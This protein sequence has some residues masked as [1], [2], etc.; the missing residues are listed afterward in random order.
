MGKYFT[1]TVKPTIA[2]S[3]QAEAAF[4]DGDALFDWTAFDLPYAAELVSVSIV[5]RGTE[6]ADQGQPHIN[7]YFAKSIGGVAPST[8]GSL[9]NAVD[10]PTVAGGEGWFNHVIG[11]YEFDEGVLGGTL[12]T[13]LTYLTALSSSIS[14]LQRQQDQA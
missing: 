10:T 14:A 13:D 2:A 5:G 3:I 9:N 12:D 8:L 4:A 6:G 11:S 7:F 1:V